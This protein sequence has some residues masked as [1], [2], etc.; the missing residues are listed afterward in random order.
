MTDR[1]I[2]F[3]DDTEINNC[4][5][6]GSAI[7]KPSCNNCK[8]K[9]ESS[10]NKLTVNKLKSRRNSTTGNGSNLALSEEQIIK[11]EKELRDTIPEDIQKLIAGQLI[12]YAF[13]SKGSNLVSTS[14]QHKFK[15]P[16]TIDFALRYLVENGVKDS[17]LVFSNDNSLIISN[18]VYDS[19]DI[20]ED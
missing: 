19:F 13:I 8:T 4:K 3:S 2:K 9:S 15:Q 17:T 7:E 16:V 5:C 12:I 10:D 11:L 1:A 20:L 18:G 6:T 14:K